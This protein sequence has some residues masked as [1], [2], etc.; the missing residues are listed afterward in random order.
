MLAYAGVHLHVAPEEAAEVSMVGLFQLLIASRTPP[1]SS[2]MSVK[3]VTL[4]LAMIDFFVLGSI[5][6]GKIAPPWQLNAYRVSRVREQ[7]YSPI[8]EKD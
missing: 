6:P 4:R 8:R 1:S 7:E 2:P 5:T 3:P